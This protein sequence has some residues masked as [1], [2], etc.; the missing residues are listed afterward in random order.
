LAD[1]KFLER[2][3]RPNQRI[4]FIALTVFRL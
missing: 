2:R 1:A 4:L 3:L